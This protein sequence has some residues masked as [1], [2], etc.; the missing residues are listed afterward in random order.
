MANI[1]RL[2]KITKHYTEVLIEQ[3]Q[4]QKNG[5]ELRSSGR[6]SNSCSASGTRHVAFVKNIVIIHKNG[7]EDGNVITTN[8]TYLVICDG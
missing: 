5:G 6:V 8:E 4:Y 1:K 2:N 7:K 3:H